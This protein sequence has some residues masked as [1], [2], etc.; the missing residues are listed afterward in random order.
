M[1]KLYKLINDQDEFTGTYGFRCPGCKM[2]HHIP[3]TGDYK[4]GFN[5]DI[6]RPTFTPS[7]LARWPY[8]NDQ[9]INVCHSFVTDGKIQFLTDCT[10]E[11]AGKTVNLEEVE[12]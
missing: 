4:W 1:A 6:D 9:I 8:G 3:T 10:H 12:V 7:I 11:M 5:G 2:S